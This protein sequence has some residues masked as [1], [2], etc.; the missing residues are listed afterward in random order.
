M[1][2][3][4]QFHKLVHH[5]MN[6]FFSLAAVKPICFQAELLVEGVDEVGLVV[7]EGVTIWEHITDP[8]MDSKHMFGDEGHSCLCIC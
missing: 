6:I 3:E 2:G 7:E 4:L 5:L 1:Y 8:I